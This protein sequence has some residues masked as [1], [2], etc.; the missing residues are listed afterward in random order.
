MCVCMYV[1]VR[2]RGKEERIETENG[3]RKAAG[4]NISTNSRARTRR[5]F[6]ENFRFAPRAVYFV[7]T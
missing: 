1:C 3:T 6:R 2:E 5:S 7:E 4:G